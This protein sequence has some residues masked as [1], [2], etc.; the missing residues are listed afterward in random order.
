[1]RFGHTL[2]NPVVRRLDT[3]FS[4]IPEG[5]LALHQAFFSPWR[6]VEEGG[7][8]PILRGLFSVPAKFS[9]QGLASD[10]TERLFEVALVLLTIKLRSCTITE[11]AP[12]LQG[13]LLVE[14]GLPLSHL[15]HYAKLLNGH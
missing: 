2:V 9:N 3:N 12:T 13:L 1:M 6:L 15:R 8:D 14:N 7:L 5:D 10:L 11:K 4:S